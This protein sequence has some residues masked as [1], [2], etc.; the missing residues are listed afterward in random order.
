M[1]FLHQDRRM[2]HRDIKPANLLMN[3]RGEPK[4]TDFG[5]STGLDHS[6]AMVSKGRASWKLHEGL[7]SVGEWPQRCL[8][9]PLQLIVASVWAWTTH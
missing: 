4:I 2:V 3:L 6:L 1:Q 9:S 7:S 8:V 5:I